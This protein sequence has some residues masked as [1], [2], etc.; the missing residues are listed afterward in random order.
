VSNLK[1]RIEQ[2]EQTQGGDEDD[3]E[4]LVVYAGGS[5]PLEM[6]P[7]EWREYERTHPGDY[8]TIREVV[9]DDNEQEAT[10]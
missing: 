2:L 10:E 7:E 1:T 4:V 9:E 6:T 3:F 8:I 5:E